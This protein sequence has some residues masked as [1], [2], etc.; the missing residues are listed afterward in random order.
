M[1]AS[2]YVYHAKKSFHQGYPKNFSSAAPNQIFNDPI[3]GPY[4]MDI[5]FEYK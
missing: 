1:T 3:D 4:D 5:N 2:V